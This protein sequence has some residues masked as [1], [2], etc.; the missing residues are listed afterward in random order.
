MFSDDVW[1]DIYC[2]LT[3]I[4]KLHLQLAFCLPDV[5]CAIINVRCP[6]VSLPETFALQWL[7]YGGLGVEARALIHRWRRLKPLPQ[8]VCKDLDCIRWFD[9]AEIIPH[10]WV[11]RSHHPFLHEDIP[12]ATLVLMDD[13]PTRK[14]LARR[15]EWTNVVPE[16]GQPFS[17]PNVV[18][19]SV[20]L[21]AMA[22]LSASSFPALQSVEIGHY[23]PNWWDPIHP[24]PWATWTQIRSITFGPNTNVY[25]IPELALPHLKECRFEQLYSHQI[26]NCLEHQASHIE[27]LVFEYSNLPNR[28]PVF[29][30]VR[31]LSIVHSSLPRTI[32]WRETFP[33]LEELSIRRSEFG[34]LKPLFS[35]GL[36]KVAVTIHLPSTQQ[37]A[38]TS[39]TTIPNV[40]LKYYT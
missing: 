19:M 4:D 5:W 35:S 21:A 25:M 6:F 33:A 34:F 20:S 12:F 7:A 17:F 32:S 37:T 3:S 31:S 28:L 1:T 10:S 24:I 14:C 38:I 16:E 22:K 11:F 36:E 8:G 39:F 40:T 26:A 15:V 30:A 29:P 13:V 9:I 27:R 2:G 23:A 18:E